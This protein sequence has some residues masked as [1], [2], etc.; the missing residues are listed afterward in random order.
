MSI[1]DYATTCEEI[2]FYSS[3]YFPKNTSLDISCIHL[4]SQ[5]MLHARMGPF[6][7]RV[8]R[9]MSSYAVYGHNPYTVPSDVPLPTHSDCMAQLL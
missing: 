6:R 8:E 4:G 2:E 5:T 9:P 3:P 7:G 1:E